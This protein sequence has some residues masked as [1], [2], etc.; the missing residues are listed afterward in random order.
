M[1][2][3]GTYLLFLCLFIGLPILGLMVVGW[4][5]LWKARRALGW[6]V[7]GALVG[8]WAWDALSV[9]WR[10]WYYDPNNITGLWFL[11]L[12]LEEWL[13]ILG[14]ALMFGSLTVILAER[15]RPA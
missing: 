8:G 9:Q 15:H 11:G 1:F 6:V 13:W 7:A 2:G 10:V 12:P 3:H 14:I 4:R 5:K